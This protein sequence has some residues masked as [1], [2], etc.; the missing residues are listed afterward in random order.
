MCVCVSGPVSQYISSLVRDRR[1]YIFVFVYFRY[2]VIPGVDLPVGKVMFL[3]V[4]QSGIILFPHTPSFFS[5]APL[6]TI[7]FSLLPL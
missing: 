6:N 3:D 2:K 7:I 1:V 5:L 4:P